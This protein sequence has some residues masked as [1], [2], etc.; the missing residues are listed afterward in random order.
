MTYLLT[1]SIGPVQEFIAAARK[2]AD[3]YAGS[4][5]LVSVVK[6]AV[7]ALD[8]SG[9]EFIFPADQN[10]DG[11]NK[12]LV[13]V[14]S[15]PAEAAASAKAAAQAFLL[16]EFEAA[17]RSIK[18]FIEPE[19]AKDQIEHFLEF[20][21]AW[22]EETGDYAKDRQN[23]DKLLSGRKTLRDFQSF[24]QE[25]DGI[26]KSPLDPAFACVF[27]GGKV[28]K[29]LIDQ[30]RFKASEV[31]DAVS[32]LKREWG[33]AQTD[34]VTN[35]HQLA[36]WAKFP[37]EKPPADP[38]RPG[39]TKPAYPYYAILVADGDSM[40]A[41]LEALER[42]GGA[43]AHR[44]FSLKLDKFADGARKTVLKYD[45]FPIYTGGDDVLALLPVTKA[46]ACAD[47]LRQDFASSTGCTLSAGIAI[48]HYR[49][50]LSTSLRQARKAEKAAKSVENKNAVCVALHTRGGSP[51]SVAQHWDE[52]TELVGW[53]R[54]SVEEK[55]PRGLPYEL[56]EL[57]REWPQDFASEVLRDEAQ[58]I[59][60]RKVR[61][62]GLKANLQIPARVTSPKELTQLAHT[63]ILARF[64]SGKGDHA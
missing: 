10:S 41:K 36:H 23:V 30:N 47:Q 48:V 16:A 39:E 11:A 6:A 61:Q 7:K 60:D 5:L 63:L 45:G 64:L 24:S 57:A 21:A 55:L 28:P 59:A 46:L 27:K 50:P 62:D 52:A 49:E 34:K 4:S 18:D 9:A 53:L 31:L 54:L 2:T 43:E 40:G 58:R 26:P 35:T 22:V 56:R 20:Y 51:L 12:I 17:T 44:E 14:Q 15:D 3:L 8:Q 13:R 25:D 19:R 42:A 32:L 29:A 33:R 37:G 1:I 38:E